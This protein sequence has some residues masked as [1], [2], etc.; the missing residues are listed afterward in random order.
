MTPKYGFVIRRKMVFSNSTFEEE[1][2]DEEEEETVGET[3]H[4][5]ALQVNCTHLKKHPSSGK[6]PKLPLQSLNFALL[7][8][9]IKWTI[10]H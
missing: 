7:R 10:A 3:T 9:M 4:Q 5:Y 8:K 6:K 1:E 2:E